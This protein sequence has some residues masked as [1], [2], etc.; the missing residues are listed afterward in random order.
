MVPKSLKTY[1]ERKCP[2]I[3]T[4]YN[5]RLEI[6]PSSNTLG[7]PLVWDATCVDTL[8]LI[9]QIHR[10]VQALQLR[11]LRLWTTLHFAECT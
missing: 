3:N 4:N 5:F 2:F 1:V 8:A 6:K 7:R 9:F 10:A 11:L